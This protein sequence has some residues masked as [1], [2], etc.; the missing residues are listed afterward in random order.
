M[1]TRA[2]TLKAHEN[3][4]GSL[5]SGW[6]THPALALGNREKQ[7]ARAEAERSS[8]PSG[9]AGKRPA[10]VVEELELRGVLE[11]GGPDHRLEGGAP[12]ARGPHH[13]DSLLGRLE[14]HAAP[15]AGSP[16]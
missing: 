2:R 11:E 12:S 5:P 4:S 8:A 16:P 10:A 9:Y 7:P 3:P 14:S 6:S 13:D 1:E 15:L